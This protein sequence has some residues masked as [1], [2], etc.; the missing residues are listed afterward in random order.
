M[1]RRILTPLVGFGMAAAGLSKLAGEGGYQRLYRHW[2][3]TREQMRLSGMAELAGGLLMAS[4]RTR[5]LGG[6]VMVG[7]S[8]VMLSTELR[9]HDDGMAA[10][11]GL[12]L[13]TSLI[14][15]LGSSRS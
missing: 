12:V 15:L 11:R 7:S 5:R 9:H 2:G 1:I 10:A 14:A 3:W 6:A 13:L 4:R 8:A